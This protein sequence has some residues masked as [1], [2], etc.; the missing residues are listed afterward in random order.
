MDSSGNVYITGS[1]G[2]EHPFT[3]LLFPQS[4]IFGPGEN[5]ETTLTSDG[6]RDIFVAKF[7]DAVLINPPVIVEAR[8]AAS[9][10]DAEEII[11]LGTVNLGSR[12]LEMAEKNNKGRLVG[13]RFNDLSIPKDAIITKAYLQFQ[14]ND[15]NSDSGGSLGIVGEVTD[16][17]ATFLAINTN[18]SSRI[19]TGAEVVWMPEQWSTQNE[20]GPDQKTPNIA[21]V[22]QEIINQAGWSSGNS[23]V[24]IITGNAP[25]SAE[26]FD[27]DPAAAPLLHVEYRLET[28]ANPDPLLTVDAGPD[29]TI[30]LPNNAT[31]DGTI[32]N[33]SFPM[34]PEVT[35]RWSQVS[36]PGTVTFADPNAIDT[37][38]SFDFAGTMRYS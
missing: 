30:N 16:N 25:R 35:T 34:R 28:G 27:G 22:I 26:S 11:D 19:Q 5:R 15:T 14:V 1:F 29:Q 24:L 32:N 21:P 6:F 7:S 36:G 13:M 10:D 38:A 33:I 2:N 31:L 9:S 18:I 8:I 3:P 23:L 17:A 12:D 37:T 4:A 20:A